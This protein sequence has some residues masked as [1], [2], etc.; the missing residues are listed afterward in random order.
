MQHITHLYVRE[1]SY[2]NASNPNSHAKQPKQNNKDTTRLRHA[3][4]NK[5]NTH[6]NL[7]ICIQKTST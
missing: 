5:L 1:K 7:E 3:T 2:K 6:T 4:K